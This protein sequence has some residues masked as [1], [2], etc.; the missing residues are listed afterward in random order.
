MDQANRAQS[1]PRTAPLDAQ[2]NAGISG[3]A[4][5]LDSWRWRNYTDH[6]RDLGYDLSGGTNLD[7]DEPSSTAT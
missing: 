1:A 7:S 2:V 3:E 6:L 4:S 5:D